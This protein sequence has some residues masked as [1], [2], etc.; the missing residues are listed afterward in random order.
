MKET[1]QNGLCFVHFKFVI[2]TI[3]LLGETAYPL[4]RGVPHN[5]ATTCRLR[6]KRTVDIEF[7]PAKHR[8]DPHKRLPNCREGSGCLSEYKLPATAT[9]AA[10]APAIFKS[11]EPHPSPSPSLFSSL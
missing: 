11:I 1:Y 10:A 8:F 3:Q 5:T 7:D 2:G 6:P 9:V 4:S